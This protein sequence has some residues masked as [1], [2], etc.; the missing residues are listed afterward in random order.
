MSS[1]ASYTLAS[2]ALAFSLVAP[3]AAGI[4][5]GIVYFN[6]IWCTARLFVRGGSGS[7]IIALMVLRIL[8]LAGV[9]LLAARHGAQ[10]LLAAVT[11]LLIG[12]ALVMHRSNSVAA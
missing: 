12:R 6:A 10:P 8:L 1:I 4:A 7:A 3:L 9:C 2:A 11:G 5:V